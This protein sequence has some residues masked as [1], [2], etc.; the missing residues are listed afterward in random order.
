SNSLQLSESKGCLAE[1]P[2]QEA[3][4]LAEMYL[5]TSRRRAPREAS[6]RQAVFARMRSAFETAGVWPL[7]STDIKASDYTHLGDPLRIDC[8]YSPN[9]TVKMFHALS[10]SGDS[11]AVNAAKVLAFSFP[12]LADGIMKKEGKRAHLAAL[13]EDDLSREQASVNFALTTLEQHSVQVAALSQMPKIAEQA[14]K[15]L[16]IG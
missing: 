10:L 1:T 6:A 4:T 12:Q 5:E 15:E 7:M 11:S 2:A 8:G 14:A 16:G 13:V 3:D 9:G